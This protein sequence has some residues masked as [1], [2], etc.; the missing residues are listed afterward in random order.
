MQPVREEIKRK[1]DEI[2]DK[3]LKELNK[4]INDLLIPTVKP[5]EDEKKAIDAATENYKKGE[6]DTLDDFL[7][8]IEV[9]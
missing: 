8:E 7:K 2:P 3:Y 1:V 6:Y 4:Y 9:D 5:T